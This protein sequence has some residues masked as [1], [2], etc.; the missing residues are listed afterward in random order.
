MRERKRTTERLAHDVKVSAFGDMQGSGL[1]PGNRHPKKEKQICNR[2]Q[3]VGAVVVAGVVFM[4]VDGWV[5]RCSCCCSGRRGDRKIVVVVI[6]V[7]VFW[8]AH[9]SRFVALLL[10]REE[11]GRR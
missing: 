7:V 3:L 6:F 11:A 5:V 2:V 1:S 4:E 10:V 8:V 9:C